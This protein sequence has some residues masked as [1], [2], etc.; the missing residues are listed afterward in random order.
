M[1]LCFFYFK[2]SLAEVASSLVKGKTKYKTRH[3]LIWFLGDFHFVKTFVSF[4][5]FYG[6]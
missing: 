2:I 4:V 1:L 3:N 6:R 5:S